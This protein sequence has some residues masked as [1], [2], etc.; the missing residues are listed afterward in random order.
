MNEKH[1]SDHIK[2]QS[3]ADDNNMI[4]HIHKNNKS[5][6]VSLCEKCHNDV[7]NND[8]VING[9]KQTSDG[10]VLNYHYLNNQELVEKRLR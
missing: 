5:N 9:Y 4:N 2:F 6:L 7:H 1:R 8:L 3:E 10:V